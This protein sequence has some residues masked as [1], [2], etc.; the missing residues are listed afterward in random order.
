MRTFECVHTCQAPTF[1][2]SAQFAIHTFFRLVARNSFCAIL[3]PLSSQDF[4]QNALLM[5]CIQRTIFIFF[6][7]ASHKRRMILPYSLIGFKKRLC[8]VFFVLLTLECMSCEA[9]G[10]L[11]FQRINCPGN[12]KWVTE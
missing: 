2:H 12:G 3:F 6:I 5:K 11:I 4:Y 9:G 1:T 10:W 7:I 8:Q